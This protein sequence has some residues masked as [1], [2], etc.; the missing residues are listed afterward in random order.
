MGS[1]TCSPF[2]E[3][4]EANGGYSVT[5]SKRN[6]KSKDVIKRCCG[7]RKCVKLVERRP[8][9]KET[10]PPKPVDD[11]DGKC[12]PVQVCE[13]IKKKCPKSVSVDACKFPMK[14]RLASH[15]QI[16]ESD[17][18]SE[19]RKDGD[20][21]VKRIK[22]CPPVYACKLEESNNLASRIVA[23]KERIKNNEGDEGM[24]SEVEEWRRQ[25]R[26]LEEDASGEDDELVNED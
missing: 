24:A 2:V 11:N 26:D 4:C 5:V 16:V 6:P 13:R 14:R 20:L 23:L 1:A 10:I 8:P 18:W 3:E 21:R 12:P 17:G 15:I 22:Y 25:L 9:S 19:H 7:V